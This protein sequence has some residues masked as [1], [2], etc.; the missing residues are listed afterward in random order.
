VERHN[1]CCGARLLH[2]YIF[3]HRGG[4]ANGKA[5]GRTEFFRPLGQLGRW[6]VEL[7]NEDYLRFMS[8]LH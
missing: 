4:R 6:K 8:Y 3:N 2:F 7:Q 5:K 1:F